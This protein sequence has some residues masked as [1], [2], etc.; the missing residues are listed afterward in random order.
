ME[1]DFPKSPLL[2]FHT[3]SI[4][5]PILRANSTNLQHLPQGFATLAKGRKLSVEVLQVIKRIT[6]MIAGHA[7]DF[8]N[9][10]ESD[11]APNFWSACPS[12]TVSISKEEPDID[13]LL[14]LGLWLYVA[15]EFSSRSVAESMLLWISMSRSTRQD[16]STRLMR[17]VLPRQQDEDECLMWLFEIAIAS[18]IRPDGVTLL[19]QGRALLNFRRQRFSDPKCPFDKYFKFTRAYQR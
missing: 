14:A 18:W 19:P 16:L 13:N 17:C 2:P 4:H 1:A 5:G 10:T 7:Q 15:F 9:S 3:P 8:D 11:L 6:R 12:L